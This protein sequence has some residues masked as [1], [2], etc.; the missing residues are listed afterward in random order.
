MALL[1]RAINQTKAARIAAPATPPTTPPAIAPVLVLDDVEDELG[2]LYIV[3]SVVCVV[4]V[5]KVVET[6]DKD[7]GV[8]EDVGVDET[9]CRLPLSCQRYWGIGFIASR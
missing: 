5:L 7:D 3:G 9:K 2:E 6:V 1:R 8:A 4:D